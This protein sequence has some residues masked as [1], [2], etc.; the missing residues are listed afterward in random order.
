MTRPSGFRG[1]RARS[2]GKLRKDVE[3]PRAGGKVPFTHTALRPRERGPEAHA[4]GEEPV[5]RPGARRGRSDGGAECFEAAGMGSGSCSGAIVKVEW[6]NQVGN[7][8]VS[9]WEGI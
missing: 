7:V 3:Q 8:P 2:P 5:R 6:E 1:P 9:L 4:G